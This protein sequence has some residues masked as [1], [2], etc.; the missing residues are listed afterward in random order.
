ML[1][2]S[3]SHQSLHHKQR[4]VNGK[5][6]YASTA[7]QTLLLFYML[8]WCWI[9]N[10]YKRDVAGIMTLLSSF[11]QKHW[12]FRMLLLPRVLL[13]KKR[14]NKRLFTPPCAPELKT[15]CVF[16]KSFFLIFY[17]Q[18]FIYCLDCKILDGLQGKNI[19][20]APQHRENRSKV[21]Q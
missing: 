14:K 4:R 10:M 21:A 13:E 20:F 2:Q 7:V 9:Y 6:N 19:I 5:S 15:G 17:L 8:S 3:S 16:N 12:I 11:W 1:E 18:G